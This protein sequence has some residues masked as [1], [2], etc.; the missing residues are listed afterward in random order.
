[1]GRIPE[2]LQTKLTSLMDVIVAK[3]GIRD[4]QVL[5]GAIGD[6]HSDTYPFQVGQFESDNR[7]DEQLRNIILEGNGGGQQ[8]ESYALAYRFAAYHTATDAWE[9]RGKK[10]Y[11][12]SMGDE[13]PWPD[14]TAAEV[15]RIFGIKADGDESIESLIARAQERWE[16]FHL[17]SADG[18]Y[19][20]DSRIIGRWRDLLGERFVRVEDS[21]LICE[22]IAGLIHMLESSFDADRVVSDMGLKGAAG[23][24]VKNALVPVGNTRLPKTV[25]KGS[26]PTKR[27][28][29]SGG[30][31]RI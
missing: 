28:P 16:V 15:E 19:P 30:I 11:L 5:V 13:G 26:L 18:S 23:A 25:A 1:M 24:A 27:G 7:F 10:G 22:V 17:F 14:V 6:T 2:I 20:N 12:F 31:V 3:A 9:K 8:K 21:S 29:Q 4:V